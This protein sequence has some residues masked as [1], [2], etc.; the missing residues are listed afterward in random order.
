[1]CI[2]WKCYST[3][4]WNCN[5]NL[6]KISA[7]M[8]KVRVQQQQFSNKSGT[9]K[10]KCQ[11][12]TTNKIT[13]NINNNTRTMFMVL[14]SWLTVIARVDPV[15]VAAPAIDNV[16]PRLYHFR[17]DPTTWLRSENSNTKI[18]TETSSSAVIQFVNILNDRVDVLITW[19]FLQFTL[20]T[21]TINS[22]QLVNWTYF[23]F[24]P[25]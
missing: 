16:G 2:I 8:H 6:N 10:I 12:Y 17:L 9:A 4:S 19:N 21:N 22:I 20:I 25:L 5:N 7:M 23:N 15:P 3:L 1:M 18:S 24:P 13:T 14:S 11:K